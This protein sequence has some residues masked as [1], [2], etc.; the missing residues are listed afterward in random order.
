MSLQKHF[1]FNCL[2]KEC[3]N[4]RYPML[5]LKKETLVKMEEGLNLVIGGFDNYR[6]NENLLRSTGKYTGATD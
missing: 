4:R 2:P 1:I 5:E 3:E 6:H